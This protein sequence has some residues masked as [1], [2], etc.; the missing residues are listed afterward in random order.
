[1]IT[2]YEQWSEAFEKELLHVF[3]WADITA[4][5]PGLG[6]SNMALKLLE[7]VVEHSRGPIV[8]DADALNILA[9]QKELLEKLMEMQ[10]DHE[11]RREMIL[12][13][14]PGEFGRLAGKRSLKYRKTPYP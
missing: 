7:M 3:S 11:K 14:H 6:Q 8:M 5:G 12:T 9:G 10:Q 2:A 13:P 4:V 1:M